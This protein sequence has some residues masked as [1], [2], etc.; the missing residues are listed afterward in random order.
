MINGLSFAFAA[1]HGIS[2]SAVQRISR[3]TSAS[4]VTPKDMRGNHVNCPRKINPA[5][6]KQV[7]E[8]VSCDEVPLFAAKKQASVVPIPIA[9]H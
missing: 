3:A 5:V 2:I 1:L 6:L 7:K 9:L 8:H 4:V